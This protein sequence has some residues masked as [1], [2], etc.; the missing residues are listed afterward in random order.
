MVADIYLVLLLV[1]YGFVDG[2]VRKWT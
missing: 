1:M 2:G